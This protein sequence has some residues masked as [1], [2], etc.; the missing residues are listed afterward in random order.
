MAIRPVFFIID[1][2]PYVKQVNIDFTFYSGFSVTQKQKSFKE[3]H[4]NFLKL[5]PNYNI[6]E[7]SSK[8]DTALGV[9]LS[10]FNLTVKTSM[11]EFTVETAFQSSKVFEFGGPYIDLLDKSSREAKKDERLKNSGKLVSFNYFGTVY[12]LEPKDYFY[13]WI[14]INSLNCNKSLIN[15]LMNYTAFTDIEFNPDKSIN[16]QAKAVALYVSLYKKGILE[17]ALKSQDNFLKVVY[18]NMNTGYSQN[19]FHFNK[20]DKTISLNNNIILK[21]PLDSSSRNIAT[22]IYMNQISSII[23][24]MNDIESEAID[25]CINQHEQYLLT[26]IKKLRKE[27]ENF[28]CNIQFVDKFGNEQIIEFF[29][30]NERLNQ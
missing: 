21:N 17:E 12:P 9:N 24:L 19:E 30:R 16:C 23:Q 28:I 22:E 14:Y 29:D 7:V 8:S 4:K 11:R 18:N 27:F 13:N 6:L 15:E 20:A 5:F 25:K 26:N 10:A 1:N 2:E 3:L